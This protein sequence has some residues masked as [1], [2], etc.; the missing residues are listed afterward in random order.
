VAQDLFDDGGL[1]LASVTATFGDQTRRDIYL[2]IRLNP[3]CA[4]S[5]VATACSVHPNVARYH[6]GILKDAG[7]VTETDGIRRG[8]G[9]PPRGYEITDKVPDLKPS[10]SG[11]S[12]MVALLERALEKLGPQKAE[13]VAVEVGRSFGRD[14]SSGDGG[15][16]DS[17]TAAA[18][19][20]RL[21]G[22]L[23]RYGFNARTD[24]DEVVAAACPFG[25]APGDH[26]VLCAIDRGL[27]AGMLSAWGDDAQPVRL[28]TRARSGGECRTAIS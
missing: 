4:V 22:A 8:K 21:A 15:A 5:D 18:T 1:A 23:T 28:A 27:M 17:T 10:A 11:E 9:R 25:T 6:I 14:I 2:F 19:L 3:R 12:L 20:S 7:H 16:V 13:E 24:G 26:P